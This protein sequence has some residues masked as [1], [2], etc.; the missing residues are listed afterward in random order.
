MPIQSCALSQRPSR[1]QS[2]ALDCHSGPSGQQRQAHS[3]ARTPAPHIYAVKFLQT[4]P[5][6]PPYHR[7]L[8]CGDTHPKIS[9]K[10]K[11]SLYYF[12]YCNS[13]ISYNMSAGKFKLILYYLYY[14]ILIYNYNSYTYNNW[15]VG[16]LRQPFTEISSG[17]CYFR[18]RISARLTTTEASTNRPPHL[19]RVCPGGTRTLMSVIKT[20]IINII[21]QY[22]SIK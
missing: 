8:L 4:T 2:R 5:L 16:D 21:M 17:G 6:K 10:M 3:S 13:A 11:T 1:L 9:G 15:M 12:G 7:V 22:T 19:S 20:T 18:G 14:Y